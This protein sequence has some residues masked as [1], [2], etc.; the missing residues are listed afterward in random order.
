MVSWWSSTV[1]MQK[2][3]EVNKP[4]SKTNLAH[5]ATP[6]PP[7]SLQTKR[8]TERVFTPY[9]PT[10]LT[11]S[12]LPLYS[13]HT[14]LPSPLSVPPLPF[15]HGAQDHPHHHHITI[16]FTHRPQNQ[17][18]NSHAYSKYAYT[19]VCL[20]FYPAGVS[21]TP[22]PKT[23]TSTITTEHQPPPT[24]QPSAKSPA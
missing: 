20:Y 9:P 21:V 1:A 19:Y 16:T 24:H 18:K 6:P 4:L 22:P 2:M 7:H 14:Q 23:I 3:R 8:L 5:H 10:Y 12:Y 13:L 11:P 17:T 15:P